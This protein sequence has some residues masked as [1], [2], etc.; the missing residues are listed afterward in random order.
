MSVFNDMVVYAPNLG[1][2]ISVSQ[3]ISAETDP[4]ING[5]IYDNDLTTFW[6]TP[7]LYALPAYV[8]LTIGDSSK[9]LGTIVIK[10]HKICQIFT[11]VG[12]PTGSTSQVVIQ[13]FTSNSASETTIRLFKKLSSIT[14]QMTR[15]LNEDPTVVLIPVFQITEVFLYESISV[16][17]PVREQIGGDPLD[18]SVGN[19]VDY[20]TT[21]ASLTGNY[22]SNL[23]TAW[24]VP[25]TY[26]YSGSTP[27]TLLLKLSESQK[28]SQIQVSWAVTVW[29]VTN[30]NLA[31]TLRR[32]MI[33][34][35]TDCSDTNSADYRYV[36]QDFVIT[37]T[38]IDL[39][40]GA[41]EFQCFK[42]LIFAGSS[43]FGGDILGPSIRDI[44]IMLD[45]NIIQGR[46][47]NV[48]NSRKGS[49]WDF[50]AALMG[51]GLSSTGWLSKKGAD[52]ATFFLDL[53][54]LK[55]VAG[56]EM[57]YT[58]PAG[59]I[60][61]YYSSASCANSGPNATPFQQISS[62]TNFGLFVNTAS[63]SSLSGL[64]YQFQAQCIKIVLTQPRQL[65]VNP[66]EP[67]GPDVAV[68]GVSRLSVYQMV[69]GGGLF[70]IEAMTNGIWGR[71]FDTIA[72]GP[73]QPNQWHVMSEGQSRSGIHN[74]PYRTD[75]TSQVQIIASFSQDGL[76]TM[77][78]NGVQYGSTYQS[79]T[80]MI[81]WAS[82]QD[83]RLVFG[84]TSTAFAGG[85]TP[86]AINTLLGSPPKQAFN[87]NPYLS[88]TIN[89]VTL[90]SQELSEEEAMGLY[91]AKS[92][93]TKER[94]CHCYDSCPV[95]RNKYFASGPDAVD[96]PCSG[97]GVC[98]R[99]YDP[100]KGIPNP[101]ICRCSPGFSGPAC[102]THCS[103]PS[104]GCCTDDDDC[105]TNMV[106]NNTLNYCV[107]R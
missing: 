38:N 45:R 20:D 22:N 7:A 30:I 14:I 32:Y 71:V 63:S 72:F 26:S 97:Q 52:S 85:A 29:D 96:V 36:Q 21:T 87:L 9:F 60:Q 25:P 68:F 39:Y 2:K 66:D 54:T 35:N 64:E 76:V 47:N 88:G 24:M 55:N 62:S 31:N 89:S 43:L 50:P 16:N 92:D 65:I 56:I 28:V 6:R 42:I 41:I 27:A 23:N 34:T 67:G 105:P 3:I 84:V 103:D 107:A 78:R 19:V 8:R 99:Q 94:A 91:N 1:Q 95:G 81:D 74:G 106:C 90:L 70:G 46:S 53:T 12:V 15:N 18:F 102:E 98:L 58:F 100:V 101:G 4:T 104:K 40:Q 57:D 33:F 51:D 5:F 73:Y 77:F 61:Y 44:S 83:I 69:G 49:W 75:E 80:A 93:Y 10:W 86:G 37:N 48:D 82:I 17:I 11:V 59:I 13:S 79:A